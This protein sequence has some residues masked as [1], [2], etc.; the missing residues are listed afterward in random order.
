[1]TAAVSFSLRRFVSGHGADLV[2]TVDPD[3]DVQVFEKV[4]SPRTWS[5]VVRRQTLRAAR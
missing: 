5:E 2:F 3:G 1:M 4:T